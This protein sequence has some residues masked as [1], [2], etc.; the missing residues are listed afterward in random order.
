MSNTDLHDLLERAVEPLDTMPDAV[1]EVLVAG[2]RSVRRRRTAAAIGSIAGAAAGVAA[3]VAVAGLTGG[4]SAQPPAASAATSAT[5]AVKPSEATP[6]GRRPTTTRTVPYDQAGLD[7]FL[8]GLSPTLD[9]ALPDRFGRVSQDH[10]NT[11]KVRTGTTTV[12]LS[13][14]V[15]DLRMPVTRLSSCRQLDGAPETERIKSCADRTL[16]DGSFARA[17]GETTGVHEGLSMTMPTV[18]TIYRHRLVSVDLIVDEAHPRP[19][20]ISNRE[21]LDILADPGV[22]AAYQTW[23]AHPEW[24]Y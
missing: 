8:R 10:G 24:I 4:T 6:T 2:R 20:P 12:T 7:A 3:I 16:P 18:V 15:E 1:P 22:R 9:K 14:R 21:M 5:T 23:A 19:I 17:A 13:F 11:Y